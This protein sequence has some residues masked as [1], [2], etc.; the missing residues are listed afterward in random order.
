MSP[1]SSAPPLRVRKKGVFRAIFRSPTSF[2]RNQ[3]T[4]PLRPCLGE[5]GHAFGHMDFLREAGDPATDKPFGSTV[6]NLKSAIAGESTSLY[7]PQ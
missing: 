3:N 2:R 1:L 5:T 6:D 4:D 7:A